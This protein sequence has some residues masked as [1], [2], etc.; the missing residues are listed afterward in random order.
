MRKKADRIVTATACGVRAMIGPSHLRPELDLTSLFTNRHRA[1]SQFIT[2]LDSTQGTDRYRVLNWSGVGGQGKTALLEEFERILQQRNK[3]AREKKS[4]RFGYALID[5]ENPNNRAIATAMLSIREKLRETAGLHCPTFEAALLR[6]FMMAQPGT[7]IKDLRAQFFHSGSDVLDGVIQAL[8]TAGEFG[9]ATH[10]FPGFGLLS[11]YAAKLA[12]RAGHA[13]YKWWNTRGSRAFAEIEGLS[14][15]ALLRKL[16]TYLGADLMDALAEDHPP[17]IVIL[18][19]TYEALWRGQ[20]LKDGPGMLRIDDWVRQLVQDAR[21]ALFVIAG[22]DKLRWSNVD[23]GWSDILEPH[24]LGGLNRPD[25]ETL[26]EKHRVVE[27]AIKDR[28][29]KGA[30]SQE[31][32]EVDPSDAAAEACLPFYLT[33]QAGTYHDIKVA[34]GTPKPEDFGG[35]HPLIL[36]RF[37]EHLD[38]ETDRLLRLASYPAALEPAVLDVLADRFLGSRAAADWSRLYTRSLVSEERDDSRHLHDLL[39]QALQERE[40]RERPELYRDIHRA[41]FSWFAQRCE[42]SDP[43]AITVQHERCFLAALRHLSRVDER[44]AVRWSIRQMQ[45]FED[46]ARWRALE[47]ACTVVLAIA[48]RAFGA[49]DPWTT[50]NLSWLA[51][52]YR[53]TG[54]YADAEQLFEQVRRSTRRRSGR[55]IPPSPTRSPTWP[56]STTTRA[57]TPT[58]AFHLMTASKKGV[59]AHQLHRMLDLGYEAAWFMAHRIRAAMSAGSLA[60]PLGGRGMIVEVD[61]TYFGK[62]DSPRP[63]SRGRIPQPTKKGRSGPAGKRAVVALVERGGRV[64]TFHPAVANKAEV[65]K[66]V[67]RNVA[68]ESRLHTDESRL[69]TEVGQ[70]FATH[71]TVKHS[72]GEYVR[73]DVHINSAEGFFSIFKRGMRGIYQHCAEKHLHRYLAEYDFRYNHRIRL[74]F[75]DAERA[76]LAIRGAGSKRLMYRQ[77]NGN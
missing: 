28:M 72:A 54:R 16:P 17:R 57:A 66:I 20:G 45:R 5:F 1:K 35:D 74:G 40:R 10:L 76:L 73:V 75:D 55:S 62:E 37:L 49:E 38:S 4:P 61:E 53:D 48:E 29:I 15:D 8:N 47:E 25:A 7:S 31:F 30:R 68:H 24:L 50:A 60:A 46:A 39:R 63:R 65:I 19:D 52:V 13:F 70:T 42:E 69:Y 41:L 9:A 33:L 21:G 23:A 58:Q 12:G 36:A 51:R 64:R 34:G 77:P 18:F 44:E 26:L 3:A 22:R 2:A 11:K 67:S 59:S 14:Q 56:T 71:E 43:R 27:P 6:Y 32:G